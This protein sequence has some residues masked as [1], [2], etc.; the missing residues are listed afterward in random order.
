MTCC[1]RGEGADQGKETWNVCR[2]RLLH[3]MEQVSSA[4][5]RHVEGAHRLE[6][7]A[8]LSLR[9]AVVLSRHSAT[10]HD[11]LYHHDNADIISVPI[12][13]NMHHSMSLLSLAC[14]ST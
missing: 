8:A 4:S 3:C 10:L 13:C 7:Q 14:T 9:F 1:G 6:C 11:E 2:L 12:I 5:W